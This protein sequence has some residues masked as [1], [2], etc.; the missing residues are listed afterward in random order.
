VNLTPEE[1]VTLAGL[2]RFVM[3]FEALPERERRRALG[4]ASRELGLHAADVRIVEDTRAGYRDAA[5]VVEIVSTDLDVWL[6][7]AAR[8]VPDGLTLRN[9]A[10]EVGD[11]TTRIAMLR[12]VEILARHEG[13]Q[14]QERLFLGWLAGFWGVPSVLSDEDRD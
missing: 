9:R 13:L 2:L 3:R 6:E 14:R 7:R 11:R 5:R 12:A 10:A 8:E 4:E 1:L